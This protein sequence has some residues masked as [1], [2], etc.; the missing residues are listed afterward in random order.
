MALLF[1]LAPSLSPA[2]WRRADL[3]HKE[4]CLFLLIC[5]MPTLSTDLSTICL[6]PTLSTNLSTRFLS[7]FS[8]KIEDRVKKWWLTLLKNVVRQINNPWLLGASDYDSDNQRKHWHQE[9]KNGREFFV[10]LF[11]FRKS[12]NSKAHVYTGEFGTSPALS[13]LDAYLEE[14]GEANTYLQQSCSTQ[15]QPAKISCVSPNQK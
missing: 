7:L 12:G 10:C 1:I 13:V 3:T 14:F 8:T 2:Q 9:K 4:P 15:D 11:V 5:L 6:M